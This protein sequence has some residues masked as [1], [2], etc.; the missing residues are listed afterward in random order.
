MKALLISGGTLQQ[1]SWNIEDILNEI[2]QTTK[3]LKERMEFQ[4]QYLKREEFY[5][6]HS[7][8]LTER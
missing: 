6:N 4:E 1:T 7:L 5:Y 8:Q 3:D 2:P